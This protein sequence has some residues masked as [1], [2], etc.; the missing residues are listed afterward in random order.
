MHTLRLHLI[1]P[2]FTDYNNPQIKNY[3]LKSRYKLGYEP[4]EISPLG[5][6]FS[7]LGYDIGFYFLSALKQYGRNF[8]QCID[9]VE[10]DQ[11][12]TNFNFQKA[13]SGGYVNNN[14]NVIS[15]NEDFTVEKIAIVN[16]LPVMPVNILPV[17]EVIPDTMPQ[18][19]PGQK[20][21]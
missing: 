11:L 18:E 16:G 8:N 2:F 10:A 15:Y 7:M 4:Y 21:P 3:L 19:L 17:P 20:W 14:Y 6:N 1:S 5:Y 13:A 12:L 9:Q